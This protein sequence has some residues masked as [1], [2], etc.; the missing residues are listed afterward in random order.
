MALIEPISAINS[1]EGYKYQGNVAL[2][3]TLFEIRKHILKREPLDGYKVQIEGEEDFSLLNDQ[4][5]LSLHQ[6]KLGKINLNDNDKFAFITEI[7]QNNAHK[8]FFHIRTGKSI[9]TDFLRTSR[10]VIK[11]L[12]IEFQKPIISKAE[13]L[14][15]DNADDYIILEGVTPV[16]E[17][18][19]KYSIIKYNTGGKK[20]RTSVE[21]AVENIKKELQQLENIE[22]ENS[23]SHPTKSEDKIYVD[24]WSDKFNNSREVKEKGVQI[25]KDIIMAVQPNWTFAD[26]K[27]LFWHPC[28]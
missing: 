21:K 24:E 26:D 19:S 14:S 25:I 28:G 16:H 6:V 7:I 13:L 12:K 22:Q 8:G 5:Y 17:K 9:P 15:Q 18:A 10:D 4:V 23:T 20:D 1:W 2:Y 3:V 11:K 27:W